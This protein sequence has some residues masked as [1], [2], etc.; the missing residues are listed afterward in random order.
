M[1]RYI[2]SLCG[3]CL[4]ALAASTITGVSAAPTVKFIGADPTTGSSRAAIVDPVPLA[5]T[6]QL[7]PVN[8]KGEIIGKGDIAKQTAQVLKNLSAVLSSAKSDTKQIVKLNVYVARAELTDEVNNV[9][10]ATF[11]GATKPA[12]TFVGG[13]LPLP[14]ALVAMDA[15]GRS[16]V[17]DSAVKKFKPRDSKTADVAILP[18]KAAAI[19]VAGMADKS[20]LRDATRITME[21]L[22]GAISHFGLAHKDIVQLKAFIQPMS[23]VDVVRE[24]IV[25]FFGEELTPPIVYVDWI[26][27]GVPIEI[28]LIAAAPAEQNA[29][30][31]VSYITPP[32]T[33][34]SQVFSRVARI[35]SGKRIYISGLYGKT[36]PENDAKEIY[37]QLDELL[38]QTGG[39][40]NHLVKATYYFSEP[41]SNG[42]L[43]V[44]RPKIYDPKRPPAASKA[45]VK[46][47]GMPGK[48]I[49][50]DMIAV[51][52]K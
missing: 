17:S 43:D 13:D 49:C 14:D 33:T 19:Y 15:V 10:A 31:S 38:K 48:G 47:V 4:L 46:D 21:K 51:T 32:G 28:E 40:I 27:G 42:R 36:A 30:N 41:A 18:E 11:K 37:E 16:K 52:P 39:D 35:N 8:D 25:K 2:S 29:T 44:L 6:A 5:H 23:Q 7:L 22:K 34:A 3:I 12:I 45:R 24:E 50:I 20:E 1:I 9:L 26:G